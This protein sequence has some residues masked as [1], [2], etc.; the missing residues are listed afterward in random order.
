MKKSYSGCIYIQQT[1]SHGS[2]Q[3][4]IALACVASVSVRFRRKERGTR[5][6]DREKSGASKRAGRGWGRKEGN[7]LS[8]FSSRFISRAVKTESPLPQYFFGPKPNGN[9]CYAGYIASTKHDRRVL[10]F[11]FLCL[12]EYT[13]GSEFT[14]NVCWEDV[15]REQAQN[16]YFLNKAISAE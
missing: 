13:T 3:E 11:W 8:L 7:P 15:L 10:R 2:T 4:P 5:V 12:F 14:T 16:E 9:A 6:K 1:D